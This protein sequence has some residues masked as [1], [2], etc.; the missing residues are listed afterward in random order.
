MI[1]NWENAIFCKIKEIM[2]LLLSVLDQD[3]K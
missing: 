3:Y 2:V 1:F